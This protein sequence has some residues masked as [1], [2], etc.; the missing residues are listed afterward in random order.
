MTTATYS[1][2]ASTD[3]NK[4]W[5]KVQTKVH[6]GIKFM[7]EEWEMLEDL[8]QFDVAWSSREILVPLDVNEG[9]NIASI[10]EG[11]YEARPSSP[12]VEELSISWVL[13]NGRFTVTKTTHW[14]EQRSPRAQIE[15]QMK[16]QAMK[17]LQDLGRHWSDYYYGF[18]TAYLAQCD[19]AQ[20]A[21][22]SHT[23]TLKNGYGRSEVSATTSPAYVADKFKVGD[24][25]ALIQSSALVTNAI[26]SITAV[27]KTNGTIAVTWNGSVTITDSDYIVKANSL[28]N[29]TVAGTDFNKGLVGILDAIYSTSVH[30]LSGAS[31][32]GWNPVTTDTAGSRLTGVRIHRAAQEIKNTGGGKMDIMYLDQGV[33]RDMIA[34]QQAALR[35]QNP[36]NMEMDGSVKSEGVKFHATE[37]VPP[38]MAIAGVKASHR[39]M[40]LLPKPKSGPTWE[41]G[42]K[43][44]DRSAYVFSIDFPCAMVWLN[45]GNWKAHTGLATQ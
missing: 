38:K 35:F 43:I 29:T 20:S 22:T 2:T 40:T 14:I 8:R 21:A 30:S 6:R 19:G 16:F 23:I 33:E 12:N 45:R 3:I 1:P 17:K 4:I 11:G 9:A 41:D 37:R 39:R 10:P 42:D 18:S 32:D 13:F 28:E 24:Y 26:G 15:K 7:S 25:V 5:R 27:D 31:V 44:Q 34:L 36:F